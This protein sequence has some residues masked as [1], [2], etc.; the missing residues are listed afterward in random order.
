MG[1]AGREGF[2][3]HPARRQ[4]IGVSGR[5]PGGLRGRPA[6]LALAG[7]GGGWLERREA[8]LLRRHPPRLLTPLSLPQ[9][10]ADVARRDAR[11]QAFALPGRS[12]RGSPRAQSGAGAGTAAARAVTIDLIASSSRDEPVL[13]KGGAGVD[14]CRVAP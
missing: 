9:P 3:P 7:S 6:A 1:S 5:V 14:P 8:S 11:D 13:A 4:G 12:R 10:Q 2:S